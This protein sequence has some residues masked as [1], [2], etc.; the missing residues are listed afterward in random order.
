M[1]PETDVAKELARFTAFDGYTPAELA[2]LVK[3]RLPHEIADG[4]TFITQ[5]NLPKEVLFLLS[6]LVFVYRRLPDE[7]QRAGK[8]ESRAIPLGFLREPHI[9]GEFEP[10]LPSS[11]YVASVRSVTTLEVWS[12]PVEEFIAMS[13]RMG[14]NL[15][16]AICEKINHAV[17]FA[18]TTAVTTKKSAMLN[19]IELYAKTLGV[20]EDDEGFLH[21]DRALKPSR[22]GKFADCGV[23]HRE[24]F[25]K[26]LSSEGVLVYDEGQED[27]K[28]KSYKIHLVRAR[29]LMEGNNSEQGW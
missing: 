24:N 7:R 13:E 17:I 9:L 1:K 20:E 10:M 6:G 15:T 3:G 8:T 14:T 27:D 29:S 23:S 25:F 22:V 12:I 28:E 2:D 16:K 21:I 5:G 19:V 11:T 18:E 26:K 4:K